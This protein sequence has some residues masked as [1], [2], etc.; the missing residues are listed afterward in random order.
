MK[1]KIGSYEP[2]VVKKGYNETTLPVKEGG[3]FWLVHT[4]VG[5]GIDCATQEEAEVL[6]RLVRIENKLDKLLRKNVK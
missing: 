2:L 4:E 6:S 5:G 1:P 3:V